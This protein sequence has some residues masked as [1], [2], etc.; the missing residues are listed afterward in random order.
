MKRLTKTKKNNVQILHG[1]SPTSPKIFSSIRILSVPALRSVALG[2]KLLGHHR[3]STNF[4][5]V[6]VFSTLELFS[7]IS[8]IRKAISI[9]LGSYDIFFQ[10]TTVSYII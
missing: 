6:V 7:T 8:S 4:R 10:E 1:R 2:K 3:K 9:I 5:H